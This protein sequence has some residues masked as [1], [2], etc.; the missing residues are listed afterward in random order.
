MKS[1]RDRLQ[2][3]EHLDYLGQ[4]IRNYW[5]AHLPREFKALQQRGEDP[6]FFL[7]SQKGAHELLLRLKGKLPPGGADEVLREL[8][9][10]LNEAEKSQLTPL[11][12]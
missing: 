8:Y 6:A 11:P 2:K 12:L 4:Q 5:K 10:P 9:F 1:L 3:R 7:E